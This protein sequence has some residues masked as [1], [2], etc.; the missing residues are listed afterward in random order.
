MDIADTSGVHQLQQG[1]ISAGFYA[2]GAPFT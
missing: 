1:G 2:S